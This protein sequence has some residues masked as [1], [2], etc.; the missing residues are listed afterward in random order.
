M[1]IKN[2]LLSLIVVFS[3]PAFAGLSAV[4]LP[5]ENFKV[6]R[7]REILRNI[8]DV[9]T[10]QQDK[11]AWGVATK[12]ENLDFTQVAEVES[13]EKL[14]QMFVYIRDTKFV[15]NQPAPLTNRRL[16]WLYPDDGCYTR[17]ELAS[18]FTKKQSMPD[19]YKFFSFGN[20]SVKTA[21]HP[22]GVVHWWYHVVP[23]YR[24]AQQAYVLDPSID[25][26][27]PMTVQDWKKAQ[28]I[29]EPVEKFAVCKPKTVGPDESCTNGRGMSYESLIRSQE[30]FL[31]QEWERLEDLGRN[32]QAELGE[33][34]PW[35]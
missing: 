15:P 5:N 32:P 30:D 19:T 20:L 11:S 22:E 16:S 24:V 14:N 13:L 18:Y 31:H 3:T 4:R 7:T 17:A 25:P 29:D 33:A 26:R 12:F 10:L 34:P 28:E 8:L 23:I 27:G 6:A 2:F 9:N 1:N 21:N 35:K